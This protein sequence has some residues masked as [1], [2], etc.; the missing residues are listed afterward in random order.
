MFALQTA[1]SIKKSRRPLPLPSKSKS[2]AANA[3]SE[4]IRG[5]LGSGGEFYF[6]VL[7][8]SLS[9]AGKIALACS[10]T[11]CQTAHDYNPAA[12][13]CARACATAR[14]FRSEWEVENGAK[15]HKIYNA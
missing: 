15:M 13:T 5:Q 3:F 2:L 7:L 14:C 1:V 6:S 11:P 10:V 8:F 4:L 12:R 9:C